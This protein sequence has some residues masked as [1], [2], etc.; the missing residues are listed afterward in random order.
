MSIINYNFDD[1]DES[2]SK[3]KEI[4]QTIEGEVQRL[5]NIILNTQNG[6]QGAGSENYIRY[7]TDMRNK[8]SSSAQN[9]YNIVSRL[10]NSAEEA[11]QAD[12]Q[13]QYALAG[14][15]ITARN[16]FDTS[17]V[18]KTALGTAFILKK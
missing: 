1:I 17:E 8:I 5:D 16:R 12:E 14:M 18:Y 3:L 15:A 4:A 13:A 6:W 9:L 7:I 10:T 2:I 11:R